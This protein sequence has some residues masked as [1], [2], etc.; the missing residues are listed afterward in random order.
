MTGCGIFTLHCTDE[1]SE[2]PLLLTVS[3]VSVLVTWPDCF[4]PM[5][6]QHVWEATYLMTSELHREQR[7]ESQ[8]PG[9]PFKGTS[10]VNFPDFLPRILSPPMVSHSTVVGGPGNRAFNTWFLGG[11]SRCKL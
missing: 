8:G 10:R 9:I 4:S 5:L 3:G 1:M 6:R 2:I 11:Y 7:R